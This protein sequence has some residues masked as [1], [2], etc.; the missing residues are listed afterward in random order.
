M[1]GLQDILMYPVLWLYILG[2]VN[3]SREDNQIRANVLEIFLKTDKAKQ[4]QLLVADTISLAIGIWLTYWAWG[5]LMYSIRVGKESAVLYI[6]TV[7]SDVALFTG[8]LLMCVFTFSNMTT[9]FK[10]IVRINDKGEGN[11]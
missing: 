6:P 3:A 7:Y 9:R 5:F 10:E 11:A 4:V 2:S 8:L 1:M